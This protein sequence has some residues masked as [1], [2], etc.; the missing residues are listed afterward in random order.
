MIIT[1]T[2]LPR[3]AFLGGMG[4]TVALPLLDAMVPALSAMPKPVPRLGFFYAPNGTFLPNF[5][6]KEVGTSFQ[7]TPVLRPLE[8][9]RNMVTI[10]SG[11]SN[12]GAENL[13]EGGGPH[14]RVHTAWLSG[15]RPK[16]TE[17]PDLVAGTSLDQ[18]A[19][20]EL[21]KGTSLTSL[22]LTLNRG[23]GFLG[24]ENGYSGVYSDTFCWKTPTTPLPM[25]SNPRAVFERLF[26]DGGTP[27][28]REVRRRQDRSVLDLAMQEMKRLQNQ[29]GAG[30]RNTVNEYLDAVRDAEQRIQ[31]AEQNAAS[32]PEPLGAIPVGI[33]DAFDDH[34]NL[35]LDLHLLAYRADVTRVVSFQIERELNGR[36]YPW[37][38]VREGHH[39]VSHHQM[40]PDKI[41]KATKIN[42]YHMSLFAR[43]LE[44]AKN[45][46][47]GD[48]TLLDHLLLVYG[49][50][51]GDSDHHTP[52]DMPTILAGGACG[53]LKGGRHL[54]YALGTP[55]M[56]LGLSLLDKVGV[57]REQLAD[58][59][60]RL[61]DL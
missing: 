15:I 42:T 6:P 13:G 39:N 46:P 35:M 5:N 52:V 11:L 48:G 1:K 2:A 10:M 45:V 31:R 56:N 26:G 55:F 22:E 49:C 24:S 54:R 28:E 37:I 33:P 34:A 60:G 23:T 59:T 30:D 36:V 41:A 32:S 25:E 16:R 12:K 20:A 19:A 57:E 4:A 9:H 58:S 14:T 21:G 43:F 18:I 44:Q 50:G 38:G 40:D 47:D 51:M 53:Q 27:A 7:F 17:G 29:L 61:T 8:P 3:R